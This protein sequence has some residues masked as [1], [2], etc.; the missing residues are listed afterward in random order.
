MR[1]S[2][3]NIPRTEFEHKGLD[4]SVFLGFHLLVLL[5]LF[6]SLQYRKN[7]S[8]LLMI[9]LVC[10]EHKVVKGISGNKSSSRVT[11]I[12]SDGILWLWL[13]VWALF[14]FFAGAGA[15]KLRKKIKLLHE[16]R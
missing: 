2:P 15:F 9:F 14:C 13:I 5:S 3:H 12:N 1:V 7:W 11:D 4:N 6:Y 10:S 8:S 16:C